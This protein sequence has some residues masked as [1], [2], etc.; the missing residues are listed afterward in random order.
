MSIAKHFQ[1]YLQKHDVSYQVI[2]HVHSDSA[3]QSS[4]L[5]HVSARQVAKAVVLEQRNRQGFVMAVI[6]ACNKLNLSWLN[7]TLNLHLHLLEENRLASIFIDCEL[8]AVPPI[9]TLYH[10][11]T[12][13]DSALQSVGDLYLEAGD[14]RHLLRVA[15]KD[16]TKL[17]PCGVYEEVSVPRDDYPSLLSQALRPVHMQSN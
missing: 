5:A 11:R 12:I 8:G 2:E 15:P 6:P 10:M 17:N 3:M 13:W 16:L 9:G 4:H 1:H 7:E 14:H